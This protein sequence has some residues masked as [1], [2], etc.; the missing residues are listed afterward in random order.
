MPVIATTI[1]EPFSPEEIKVL[2]KASTDFVYFVNNIFS[3]SSKHFI[4]GEHVDNTAR[5][6]ASNKRTIRVSARNHFKSY[7]FYAH[8]MWKLMFEGAQDN[9]EAHYFSFNSEL[10]GYHVGK[11][12]LAI[13][14]NPYFRHCIDKKSVAESVLKYTWD[15]K[16]FTSLHPHGLIQ[17]KRGIHCDYVYVDDPFQDPDNELNPTIIKKINEIFKSNILDMPHEANGELHVAGT[18][19]TDEDFF[20]DKNTTKRFAVTILPA[21]TD[22]GKALW[23]EW[24]NI[25]ELEEKR[26]ERTNRV[27]QKEY[28]CAPVYSTEGFFN[29]D[30]K[31]RTERLFQ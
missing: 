4:G 21:I 8:F 27:F 18:P 22:E 29:K 24:M 23:P 25:Q 6:L 17:F 30:K 13:S 1:V 28:M 5:M 12:K 14:A 20:F 9:I 31:W 15:N 7:S 19:Q 10:A 11:L 26:I 3:K 16:H 2:S